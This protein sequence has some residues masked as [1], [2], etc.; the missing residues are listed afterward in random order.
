MYLYTPT[1]NYMQIKERFMQKFQENGGN[2]QVLGCCH[3]KVRELHS[4]VMAMVNC[5]GTSGRVLW[6]GT[7]A[8]SL[9]QSVFNLLQG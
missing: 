6:R 2:F 3:G 8:F 5:L 1:L 4:V 7:V 9:F